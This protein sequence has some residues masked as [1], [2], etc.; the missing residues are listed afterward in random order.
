MCVLSF[1]FFFFSFFKYDGGGAIFAEVSAKFLSRR[2]DSRC[3]KRSLV[4][5]PVYRTVVTAVI[6]QRSV[7][8]EE[9][10]ESPFRPRADARE[11]ISAC[12]NRILTRED[13][14]RMGKSG[15]KI[16]SRLSGRIGSIDRSIDN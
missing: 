6:L 8:C 16:V 12:E 9:R 7:A 3:I 11:S 2:F 1:F 13:R 5:R 4:Y 14:E 10:R 15:G